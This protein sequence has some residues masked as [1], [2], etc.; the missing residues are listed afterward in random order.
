[1]YINII[2]SIRLE[3]LPSQK[4]IYNYERLLIT[5]TINIKYLIFCFQ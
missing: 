4:R 1:M 2:I 3:N 5:I